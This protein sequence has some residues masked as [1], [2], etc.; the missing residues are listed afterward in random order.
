MVRN[1]LALVAGIVVVGI[2]VAGLQ[3]LTS[4]VY[5]LPEGLDPLDPDAADE[6]AAYV[7]DLPASAW[8]FALAS[9]L[10]GVFLGG[11][12]AG[13]IAGSRK[14]LFAGAIVALGVVGSVMN[15]MSFPHPIWF[16]LVQLVAY[17]LVFLAI[18][19]IIPSGET[20][21]R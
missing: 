20:A 18:Q 4:F 19:R 10:I 13:T 5:P 12:A 2:V 14:P 7:A 15:W 21:A 17:P 16:I 11:L 9:E 1:L 8:L 3:Y 6:F